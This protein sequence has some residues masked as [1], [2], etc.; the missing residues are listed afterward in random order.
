MFNNYNLFKYGQFVSNPG[1]RRRHSVKG[2]PAEENPSQHKN[3]KQ[4]TKDNQNL[5]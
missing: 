4:R 3:M 5:K 2:Y 1:K